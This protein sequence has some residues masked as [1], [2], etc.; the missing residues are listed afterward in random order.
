MQITP[1]AGK[2]IIN[3]LIKVFLNIFPPLQAI[4]YIGISKKKCWVNVTAKYKR[5]PCN[6]FCS[7]TRLPKTVFS[8][9]IIEVSYGNNHNLYTILSERTLAWLYLHQLI[10]VANMTQIHIFPHLKFTPKSDWQQSQIE[11]ACN[12]CS[13]R[14]K[15]RLKKC[16]L[17]DM[18]QLSC[19]WPPC[20]LQRPEFKVAPHLLWTALSYCGGKNKTKKHSMIKPLTAQESPLVQCMF[21]TSILLLIGWSLK[22]RLHIQIC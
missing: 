18:Q 17:T 2:K 11:E 19:L 6:C 3:C 22:W 12:V 16:P 9:H 20:P 5:R 7:F 8:H 21:Y 10:C 15:H 13:F 4:W 1:I 14:K